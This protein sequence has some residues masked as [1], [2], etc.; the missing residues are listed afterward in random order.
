MQE[1]FDGENYALGCD[2]L[3]GVRG[4][5]AFDPGKAHDLLHMRW[6]H[7][8]NAFFLKVWIDEEKQNG[9][10]QPKTA[11]GGAEQ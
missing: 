11:A 4:T 7:E 8:S 1:M 9:D 5:I 3:E 2:F 10:Q 6:S